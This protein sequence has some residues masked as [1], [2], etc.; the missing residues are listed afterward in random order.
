M[1]DNRFEEIVDDSVAYL[2]GS[3]SVLGPKGY[4]EVLAWLTERFADQYPFTLKRALALAIKIVGLWPADNFVFPHTINYAGALQVGDRITGGRIIY[5]EWGRVDGTIKEIDRDYLE[6]EGGD[7]C[8]PKSVYHVVWKDGWKN[9]PATQKQLE[10]LARIKD[11]FDKK[12]EIPVHESLTQGDASLLLDRWPKPGQVP[13]WE[14]GRYDD[15]SKM[16][17]DGF[18]WYCGC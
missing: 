2:V 12:D 10:L 5:D 7:H 14:C 18:G 17:D 6:I 16:Q 4:A 1:S 9:R 3:N 15:P 8:G 13:C 11:E